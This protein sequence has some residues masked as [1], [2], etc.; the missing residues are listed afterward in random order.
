MLEKWH[1]LKRKNSSMW[2]KHRVHESKGHEVN[3]EREVR[4]GSPKPQASEFYLWS[5]CEGAPDPY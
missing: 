5:R 3:L 1:V 2:L 4:A